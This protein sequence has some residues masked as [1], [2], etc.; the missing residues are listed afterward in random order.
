MRAAL[1]AVLAAFT[2][3]AATPAPA[4]TRVDLVK[5]Q[6]KALLPKVPLHTSYVVAVNKLGQVTRVVSGSPSKD[7]T[8]NLQTFGNAL[9]AFIRTPDGHAISGTYKLT[10]DYNP[11]TARIRRDVALLKVGGVDPNAEGAALQM[12]DDVQK[13]A[14]KPPAAQAERPVPLTPAST[15]PLPDLQHILKTPAP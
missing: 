9:Q 6:P 14:K 10:Y 13:H 5:M 11:K 12:I 15:Q 1:C 7:K 4:P 8:Y 3:L 2:L